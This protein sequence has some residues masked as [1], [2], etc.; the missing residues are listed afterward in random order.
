[1][2]RRLAAPH[3]MGATVETSPV[4]PERGQRSVARCRALAGPW[5]S[6]RQ[7]SRLGSHERGVDCEAITLVPSS[8]KETCMSDASEKPPGATAVRPFRV[9]IPQAEVDELRRRIAAPRRWAEPA[10]PKLIYFNEVDQGGH[11]APWQEP[12]MFSA[13]VRAA[14][15][16]LR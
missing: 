13:E 15:R 2:G 10:Y 14:F 3:P 11:F 16:S 9:E 5:Q 12:Q 7:G 4:N 1:M 6:E 8:S